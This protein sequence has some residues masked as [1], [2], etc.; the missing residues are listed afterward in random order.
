MNVGRFLLLIKLPSS[1]TF[2]QGTSSST[3]EDT[4]N[5]KAN[6]EECKWISYKSSHSSHP[7]NTDKD[8]TAAVG[9]PPDSY[10]GQY[11]AGER[12]HW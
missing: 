2:L 10:R 8:A 11:V 1:Q 12:V 9:T 7:P 5:T 6:I 4:H 3:A